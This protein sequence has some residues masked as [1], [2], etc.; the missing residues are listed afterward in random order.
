ML[1]VVI[2]EYEVVIG[3]ETHAELATIAKLFCG[4]KAQSSALNQ[5]HRCAQSALVCLAFCL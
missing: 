2:M 5:I 1:K 3:L 4:C